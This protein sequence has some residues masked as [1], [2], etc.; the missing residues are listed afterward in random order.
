MSHALET[1]ARLGPYEIVAPIGAG[2]MGEV[3]RARDTKLGREV[4][5]KVLPAAFAQDAE[6]VARFHREAQILA[7]L[8]HSNIASIFGLEES[9]SEGTLALVMELVDGEDL[10]QRLK[11]GAIPVD[12]AIA[13]AKQ[14]AE[15]LEEAHEKG[16]VHRDLKPANVKL[17]AEGKV[18][19]LDFGLAKA[20]AA[21]PMASSGAHDLSQSPTLA[22][23]A[24]T[25][26]GVI[27]GTA[28]YMSPEQARGKAVGKRADIWAFGVVLF[29]ML[30]GRRLFQGETVSDTL[31][32]VLKTD[33]DWALLPADTPRSIHRLLRRCLERDPGRRL[34]DIGDARLDLEDGAEPPVVAASAGAP[35]PSRLA[36]LAPA[37]AGALM[38]A[39]A[40]GLLWQVARPESSAPLTRLSILAPAG[41]VLFPDSN[42]V[43]ISPDGTMVAFTV[44]GLTRSESQLWV[45]S[46]D[47]MSARRLEG[48]DGA[49]LPFWSPDSRR[50]GFFADLRL[51]IIAVAGGRA[52][53]LAEAPNARGA[54]WTPSNTIV[55]APNWGG[56]LF[57]VPASGGTPEPVTK[58]DAARGEYG[59]RFPTLLPDGE[60][61]LY[62]ALPGKNGKFEIFAG[63]LRDDSR[64]RVAT[65]EG[66]PV[67]AAPG[68]LLFARQGLLTA[69]PFDARSL[70]VTGEPV[71]LE[72]E[73]RSILDPASSFT[74]GRAVS[75]SQTGALAYFTAP[76]MNTNAGW[77]DQAG[78]ITGT[79]DLPPAH[80]ETVTIS[81]DGTRAVL[82]RS[83]SPS[84]SS[85]WLVDLARGSAAPL[86]SG[87]GRNDGP[88]WS[89]DGTRVA[90]SSDR[91]GPQE[92]YV[93]TIGDATP[94]VV[95]FR[96]GQPFKNVNAWSPDGRW[97]FLSQLDEATQQDILM[98]PASGQGELVPV[99]RGPVRDRPGPLSPDGRWLAFN[100]DDTGRFE[101][102]LQSLPP[103]GRR[104]QV[105]QGGGTRSWWTADGRSLFYV[106]DL[107]RSLWQVDLRP[108]AVLGI[109][110]PR[111]IANLPPDVTWLDAMPDRKRFIAIVPEKAGPGSVT[112]VQNWRATL[113]KEKP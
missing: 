66:A 109:G 72:D 100:A 41:T 49:S 52:E 34:H 17:T 51:K 103:P 1:G 9:A 27:L 108:G 60:R 28:A 61:F 97:L 38:A 6:R 75:A 57:R 79:L 37:V 45:R 32:A 13:I 26:A 89:P 20:F 111:H 110:T 54:V 29:E 21:D 98:L 67:H 88:V 64:T 3:L 39:L 106:D 24:G 5:I 10:A 7:A 113:A 16:I 42:G 81:P 104:L 73:P 59:H 93:K 8:H 105:S 99:V 83:T 55:F 58:L 48:A 18:K 56:P 14:I 91:D 46:L 68:F 22:T 95:L 90:F 80:Y 87:Q 11:R 101:L 65:M 102:Y 53:T 33:P 4:A 82:V 12:E 19:V 30:S 70:Q 86:S 94:E 69:L 35:A 63:S 74:A 112:V 15:A 84:E 43:A 50:L 23:A 36:W 96:N 31:A 25:Q 78:R 85:L 44:G 2:G 40:A 77:M 92:I 107:G 47:T 76:A 71:T 62:A